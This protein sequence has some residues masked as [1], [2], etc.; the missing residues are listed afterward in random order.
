MR[1]QYMAPAY[2][3]NAAPDALR[4]GHRHN[5]EGV[6]SQNQAFS[7]VQQDQILSTLPYNSVRLDRS[8]H[9]RSKPLVT[10]NSVRYL[11]FGRRA[12]RIP[13]LEDGPLENPYTKVAS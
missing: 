9:P 6:T 3:S 11:A 10:P 12:T 1:L 8:T 7:G 13:V 2:I 4:A 5:S